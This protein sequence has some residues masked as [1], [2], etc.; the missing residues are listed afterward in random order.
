MRRVAKRLFQVAL[1][2][3]AVVTITFVLIRQMPGGPLG[4]LRAKLAQAGIDPSSIDN[5]EEVYFGTSS[6]DPLYVQ[7]V[8]YVTSTL[9]GDLGR[10]I[11][12][13]EDV[14]SILLEAMPWTL[15][16]MSISIALTF[17][18]GLLFGALMAY[19]EGSRLDYVG[20]I[21]SILFNSIPYYVFALALLFFAA[22]QMGWFPTGGRKSLGVTVGYNIEFVIDVFH[23]AALPIF[24]FVFTA[25]GG[26]AIAM[27]GNAISV[28]GS[29]YLRVA[30][31][32]G[33]SSNRIASRYV[34]RNAV[35]P[36]YT[37][38]LIA[39]GFMFGG[40]VIL[41]QIFQYTGVGFFMFEAISGRD[42]P[43]MMGAFLLISIAVTIA[44]FIGDMTY[45]LL[46]PRA[47]TS[48]ETQGSQSL[49][50]LA[51]NTLRWIRRRLK[52]GDSG[53]TASRT[54]RDDGD[55]VFTVRASG[56]A[57]IGRTDS[58]RDRLRT[59]PAL[60]AVLWGDARARVGIVIVGI[61]LFLG[62]VGL[63]LIPEP[64]ISQAPR[65]VRPFENMAYPLGT[66]NQ[67]QR[68]FSLMVYA[69]PP[70][71][72]M[73]LA[74]AVF[75]TTVATLV[76][77]FAGYVGGVVDRILMTLADIQIALP[78]LP[79]LIVLAAV[80][81]PESPYVLGLIISAPAWAGLA[82]NI[83]SQVLTLRDLSYVESNRIIGVPIPKIVAADILPNMMSYISVNFVY[84]ARSI[85]FSS[86]ALYFLGVL[87]VSFQNWG[88]TMNIAYNQGALQSPSRFYWILEPMLTI[89][90]LTLGMVLL[91]QGMDRIFNPRIRARHLDAGGD[92]E[93]EPEPETG[94]EDTFSARAD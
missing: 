73:I 33:L 48:D 81:Q 28:L 20:T 16:V 4:Y 8:D 5:L 68:M 23:H 84:Q 44:I 89:I 50:G 27:R 3:W 15:L 76:G 31:L 91:A 42:F 39:I 43:L 77:T 62:T 93:P 10:S 64:D 87:P 25:F 22:F 7:Y 92:A 54:L 45:S 70:M 32:R 90:L 36:M 11:I 53:E 19:H 85:I 71:L 52:T 24:S 35:L 17:A 51:R 59:L 6:D 94:G 80:F 79:L 61:Y 14:S 38:L 86:V 46:D 74:G 41:E 2:V 88:V 9:S 40:A 69:I 75:A 67:G 21:V 37:S 60:F 1:T 56:G 12:F 58:L 26:V 57:E 72:K 49:S 13:G 63:V 29:D 83:R 34:L 47:T 82:R 66:N 55:S 78:G 18:I 65:F 30:R